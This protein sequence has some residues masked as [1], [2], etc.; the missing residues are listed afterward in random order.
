MSCPRHFHGLP[1]GRRP[2][3]TLVELLVVIAIIAVLMALL[4]PAVQSVR[5]TARAT[6][7]GNNLRQLGIALEAHVAQQGQLPPGGLSTP[8]RTGFPAFV[9]P[10]VEQ[11]NRLTGYDFQ[12]NWPQQDLDVQRQMFAYLPLYH[13]PSDQARQKEQGLQISPG[14]VV[15]RYKGNYAPNFGKDTVGAAP[16]HAPFALGIR[17][18]PAAIR[19]GLSNTFA[20]LEM[21]QVAPADPGDID[22][23]GD[24]WNEGNGYHVTTKFLPN[25]ATA[26]D[27]AE[28]RTDRPALVPKCAANLDAGPAFRQT[29]Y[30]ISRSRHP[31]SV[32]CLMLDG[33]VHAVSDAIDLAIWQGLSTR[34]GGEIGQ[35]P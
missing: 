29:G 3:M 7:C 35:L 32:R 27:R 18:P 10:Y 1:A 9:L 6:Q 12:K 24:I 2:G 23:R 21:L 22:S 15:A 5:E 19:D 31:G 16:A 8:T 25:D 13:C 28:C 11:G 26:G 33:S 14:N 34:N 30:I 4:L 20:M 17:R